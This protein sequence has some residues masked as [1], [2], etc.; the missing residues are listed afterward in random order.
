MSIKKTGV[1]I[2][3][4]LHNTIYVSILSVLVAASIEDP[5]DP[6]EG[7]A[8]LIVVFLPLLILNVL[9]NTSLLFCLE[10][11]VA[12]IIGFVIGLIQIS[13]VIFI[14]SLANII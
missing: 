2:M 4:L 9:A 13:Y 10:K 14:L 11:R 5:H 8:F 6:G 7:T 3:L 1:G 12:R